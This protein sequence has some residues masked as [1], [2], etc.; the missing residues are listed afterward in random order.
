MRKPAGLYVWQV[1]CAETEGFEPSC[2]V[3]GKRISSAPRYDHF[4][5]SPLI[6]NPH[7]L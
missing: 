7:K 6:E 2:P 1:F 3:K 5:T 4:D